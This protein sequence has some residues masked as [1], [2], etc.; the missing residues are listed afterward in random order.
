MELVPRRAGLTPHGG[1]TERE[2]SDKPVCVLEPVTRL[3]G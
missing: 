1:V 2:G 3:F